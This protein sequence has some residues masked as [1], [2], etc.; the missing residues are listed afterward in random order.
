MASDRRP[1]STSSHHQPGGTPQG[2]PQTVSGGHH[3]GAVHGSPM[4]R[5]TRTIS[6]SC[7]VLATPAGLD[8]SGH[9]A[10]GLATPLKPTGRIPRDQLGGNDGRWHALRNRPTNNLGESQRIAWETTATVGSLSASWLIDSHQGFT[11]VVTVEQSNERIRRV[12]QAI[13]HRLVPLDFARFNP[14]RHL[15]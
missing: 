13:C 3:L 15:A 1:V 14:R 10:R 4:E 11:E 6:Q 7:N 9:L 2:A 5:F 8:R 12:L